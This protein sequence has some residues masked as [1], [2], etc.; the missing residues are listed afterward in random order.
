MND[1]PLP[2]PQGQPPNM[3]SGG[4]YRDERAHNAD[5]AGW[6][7]LIAALLMCAR[8]IGGRVDHSDNSE[9]IVDVVCTAENIYDVAWY[10]CGAR[11]T[12]AF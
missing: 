1:E 3:G 11:P 5:K 12:K 4:R 9:D 10:K 8:E 6:V 7:G 2:P